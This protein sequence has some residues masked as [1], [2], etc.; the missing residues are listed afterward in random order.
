MKIGRLGGLDRPIEVLS[1]G[2]EELILLGKK[3]SLLLLRLSLGESSLICSCGLLG[4][5]KGRLMLGGY[6]GALLCS[7]REAE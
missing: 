3:A 6:L 4:E 2:C 7:D 5:K 1:V